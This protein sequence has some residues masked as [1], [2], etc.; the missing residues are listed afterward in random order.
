[1]LVLLKCLSPK[2]AIENY[3]EYR[4]F[5]KVCDATQTFKYRIKPVYEF[6]VKN[7][8]VCK[9]PLAFLWMILAYM[10][11]AVAGLLLIIFII[12]RV[13]VGT[14]GGVNFIYAG[15][16]VFAF[17]V[18]ILALNLLNLGTKILLG[19]KE[20]EAALGQQLHS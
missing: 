19:R 15:V 6:R 13:E 12:N 3:L 14:V 1:M 7:W 5:L 18:I 17:F 4:F 10:M 20:L 9:I 8:L 11:T 16:L 2:T